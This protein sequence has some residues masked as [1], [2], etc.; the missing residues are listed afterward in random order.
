MNP[1][2]IRFLESWN[3]ELLARAQQVR[4]LIGD[5]HWLT[6]GRHKETLLIDFINRRLHQQYGIGTGFVVTSGSSPSSSREI[7]ILIHRRDSGTPWQTDTA[8]TFIPPECFSAQ[9]HVKSVARPAA[10]DDVLRS[11]HLTNTIVSPML[12]GGIPWAGGYFFDEADYE[13]EKWTGFISKWYQ[14]NREK[15]VP[16]ETQNI[17]LCTLGGSMV[18]IRVESR[19]RKIQIRVFK[20]GL[21]STAIFIVDLNDALSG[22]IPYFATVASIISAK[23][24][25][26]KRVEL[27]G[28]K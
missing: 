10:V 18:F 24:F 1:E 21:L 5:R 20:V 9:I 12:H 8:I 17:V 15:L 6:D 2:H 7:D 4:S 23:R 19:A 26:H 28:I 11:I 14:R 27:T 13:Y 22:G 16:R 25:D 3:S